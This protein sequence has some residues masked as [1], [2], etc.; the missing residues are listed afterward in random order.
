MKKILVLAAFFGASAAI[1]QP[2]VVEKAIIKAKTEV[3]FPENFAPP[4][5][6]IGRAH[7]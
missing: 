6:E 5:G 2:K 4:G 7:V 3:T 1:A